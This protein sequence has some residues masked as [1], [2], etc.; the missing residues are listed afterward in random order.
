MAK[1][2]H[3]NNSCKKAVVTISISGK[4]DFR[5]RNITREKDHF[6]VKKGSIHQE[7]I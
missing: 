1:I 7:D 6:I 4:V 2:S 3:A 5:T